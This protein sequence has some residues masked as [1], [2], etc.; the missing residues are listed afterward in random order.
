MSNLRL[1]GR[2]LTVAAGGTPEYEAAPRSLVWAA[3]R[4]AHTEVGSR[5]ESLIVVRREGFEPP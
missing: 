4:A 1:G 5:P 2:Q 3:L